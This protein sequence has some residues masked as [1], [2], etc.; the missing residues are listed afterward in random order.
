MG[1]PHPIVALCVKLHERRGRR[2]KMRSG[3]SADQLERYKKF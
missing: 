3:H 1:W 2:F